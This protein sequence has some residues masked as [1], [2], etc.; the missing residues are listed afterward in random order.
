[1]L[2]FLMD[3]SMH[4]AAHCFDISYFSD[5]S[6]K[7]LRAFWQKGQLK[8]IILCLELVSQGCLQTSQR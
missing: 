1:M 7:K 2:T 5:E 8:A 3:S 4:T 6:R